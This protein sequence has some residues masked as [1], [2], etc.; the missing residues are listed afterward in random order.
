MKPKEPIYIL[1]HGIEV[2]GEYG[3]NKKCPYWRVRA[4]PHRFFPGVREVSGG[5]HI[6]RSRAVLAAKIGR[7]LSTDE[8]V[9]H[10]DGDRCNDI[11]SNLELMTSADHNR[12]HKLGTTHSQESRRRISNGLKLAIIEGRKKVIRICG[13]KQWAAK[14]VDDDVRIIR[15]SKEPT[16]F[17][18]AHYGVSRTVIKQIRNGK[19][20]R[21]VI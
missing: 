12:H 19:L 5:I 8:H 6:H 14:L 20:W 9:H 7:P 10:I 21:H 11:H 18:V 17:L 3:P 4:R 16:R 1:P 2:I 13:T 15:S